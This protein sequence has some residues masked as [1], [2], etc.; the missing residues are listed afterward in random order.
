MELGA[1][2]MIGQLWNRIEG[3]KSL[4]PVLCPTIT[5]LSV[6]LPLVGYSVSMKSGSLKWTSFGLMRMIGPLI[7]GQ[8]GRMGTRADDT[9]RILGAW[10]TSAWSTE[11]Q[12]SLRSRSRTNVLVLSGIKYH[13]LLRL[14][15]S[16]IIVWVFSPASL[17]PEWLPMDAATL[18]ITKSAK[19]FRRAQ[20]CWH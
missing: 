1:G 18:R 3:A 8:S 14:M 12:G 2:W 19:W 5:G 17:G 9:D 6:F 4:L 7:R 16:K 11:P 15:R 13:P 20:S 10:H